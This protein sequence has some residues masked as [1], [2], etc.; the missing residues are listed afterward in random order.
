MT[1]STPY[2]RTGR[3]NQTA[4]TRA[5]LIAATRQLLA[6]GASPTVER[7]ADRAAVSRTTAFR[8][9]PNQRALLAATYPQLEAESLLGTPA[10][11]DP[12]ARLEAFAEQFMRHTLAFEPELRAQL[13]L[14]LEPGPRPPAEL[15]LR[16]G[17]GIAWLEDALSPLRGRL[18]AEELPRFVLAIRA[19]RVLEA[20]IGL[21]DV[22]G[23]PREQAVDIMRSSARTLVRAAIA[24]A[25]P[26]RE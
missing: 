3:T 10:P 8:Y 12:L 25:A 19:T 24:D 13:R 5:A 15:P 2:A 22:A 14:A 21:T 11:A 1:M 7:A 9:F 16:Q 18:P 26:P 20:L 17:R 23:V 4:R 6:E